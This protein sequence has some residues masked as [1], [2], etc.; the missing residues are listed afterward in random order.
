MQNRLN[1]ILQRKISAMQFYLNKYAESNEQRHLDKAMQAFD[2][3]Q[4]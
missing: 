3:V 2:E 4:D 1:Y